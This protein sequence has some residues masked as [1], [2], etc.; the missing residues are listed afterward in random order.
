VYDD[1]MSIHS[2]EGYV[3]ELD[4][5]LELRVRDVGSSRVRVSGESWRI[6]A[7]IMGATDLTM[8]QIDEMISDVTDPSASGV[9][10]WKFGEQ[11]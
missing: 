7:W 4:E 8:E 10:S 5:H 9:L 3:L 11:S 2:H 1:G 6:S